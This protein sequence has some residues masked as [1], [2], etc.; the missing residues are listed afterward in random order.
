MCTSKN[1]GLVHPECTAGTYELL[2]HFV[3][4]SAAQVVREKF[5]KSV[6]LFSP[7]GIC[8]FLID[9]VRSVGPV[10]VRV[11]ASQSVGLVGVG[12]HLVPAEDVASAQER[13]QVEAGQERRQQGEQQHEQR[14]LSE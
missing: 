3:L 12:L 4:Y 7:H 1:C 6:C 11:L 10:F 14:H 2:S 9:Q 8:S 13:H 5:S